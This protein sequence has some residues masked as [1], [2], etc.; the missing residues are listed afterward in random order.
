MTRLLASAL[1]AAAL[2]A[3]PAA[4]AVDIENQDGID[5]QVTVAI[6]DGGP[7]TFTLRAG[8]KKKDIC[9]GEHCVLMLDNAEWDGMGDEMV[10][11]K[12]GKMQLPTR[13]AGG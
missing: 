8:E 2:V 13:G 4:Y 3:A 11:V 6:G 9:G 5:H 7:S 1:F 10:V 12:D